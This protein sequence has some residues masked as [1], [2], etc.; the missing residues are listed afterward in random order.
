MMN[1]CM[2]CGTELE[3]KYLENEG[4]ILYCKGCEGYRF[5][6]FNTA[7]SMII[8][9]QEQNKILLIKQY[10]GTDFIL[11]AGYVNKGENAEQAAAREIAEELGLE[12]VGLRYNK[13]EYFGKNNTLMLNFVCTVGSESLDR[14]TDEVDQAEWFAREAARLHIKKGSLAQRFL[15][16]YLE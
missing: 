13:S 12:A 16:N 4:M 9:N 10:G 5:P 7:V 8:L 3:G 1:Y 15:E 14:M 6:V 11:C 2:E